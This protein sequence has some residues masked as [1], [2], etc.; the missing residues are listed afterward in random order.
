MK[1]PEAIAKGLVLGAVPGI[2]CKVISG[3]PARTKCAPAP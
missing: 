3:I 1:E 2:I